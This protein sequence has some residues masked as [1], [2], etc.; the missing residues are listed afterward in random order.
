[1]FAKSR[2]KRRRKREV[3]RE[4]AAMSGGMLRKRTRNGSEQCDELQAEQGEANAADAASAANA[5]QVA[6]QVFAVFCSAMEGAQA[7][8]EDAAEAGQT[9]RENNT[10]KEEAEDGGESGSGEDSESGSGQDSD[11]SSEGDGENSKDEDP[12]LGECEFHSLRIEFEYVLTHN[13][14]Y[15]A[16]FDEKKFKAFHEAGMILLGPFY[17][18]LMA[19]C[20]GSPPEFLRAIKAAAEEAAVKAAQETALSQTRSTLLKEAVSLAVYNYAC[21]K[22][23]KKHPLTGKKIYFSHL[24]ATKDYKPGENSF[25]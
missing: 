15:T 13:E 9:A 8:D 7:G 1:M 4:N 14:K 19:E 16:P 23:P 3:T 5:M 25:V 10:A 22:T 18:V 11:S 20:I 12:F 2:A 24:F 21:N 17:S 6:E